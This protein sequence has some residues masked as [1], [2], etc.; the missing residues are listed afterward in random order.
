[1]LRLVGA[2]LVFA[3]IGL[4]NAREGED[5]LRPYRG[6]IAGEHQVRPYAHGANAGEREV[7]PYGQCNCSC[8]NWNVPTPWIVCGPSKYSIVVRSGIFRSA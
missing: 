1:V 4:E 3:L 2:N 6:A 5:K 7:R 8:R